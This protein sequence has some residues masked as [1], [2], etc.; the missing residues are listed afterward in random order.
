[1]KKYN[2]GILSPSNIAF[3]RFLP[4]LK[5]SEYFNY[6]GLAVA[7]KEEW[8]KTDDKDIEDDVIN[9]EIEKTKVFTGKFNGDIF[10]SYEDLLNSDNIDVV[11]IPLPPA[12]HYKWAKKALEKGKH[13]LL[14]KPFTTSKDDTFNLIDIAV[15]NNLAVFEN[16]MFTYHSQ[17][18]TI[19]NM[20]DSG[21]VGDIRGY[22]MTFGFPMRGSKDFRYIKELGGGALLDCGGYPIKLANI[23]LGDTAKVV[24]SKLN[25]LEKFDVD[26]FGS[27]VLENNNGITAYV[28]FGMDNSYQCELEVWGSKQTIIATRVFT[29]GTGFNPELIIKTSTDTKT[30]ILES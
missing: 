7:N 4:S 3:N 25:Y 21:E 1:M 12:L 23:L 10:Y 26:I 22:K 9:K 18:N 2:L 27:A 5:K 17:I 29:A 15:K 20:I 8:F 11:Y 24:Y 19:R 13:I 6:T 30:I 28:T 16:Y 14:E